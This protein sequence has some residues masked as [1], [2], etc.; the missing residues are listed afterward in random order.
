[1]DKGEFASMQFVIKAL[2]RVLPKP[3]KHLLWETA[4]GAQ[5]LSRATAE[6]IERFRIRRML[7][8]PAY[9][10]HVRR[11]Y[12]A[13]A[14]EVVFVSDV[15][16]GREAKF[17]H[18]LRGRG[19]TVTLL[20][21]TAPNY[22]VRRY[23]DRSIAYSDADALLGHASAMRPVAY[24][25][26]SLAGDTS[27]IRLINAKIGPTVFDT[28]DLLEASYLGNA[29]SLEKARHLIDMQAYALRYADGYC[30][31]DLQFRYARRLLGYKLG[32]RPIFFPEYCWGTAQLPLGNEV[33]DPTRTIRCVMAGN[34]G[35][36]KLGQGDWGYLEI[37]K[38]FSAAKIALDLY[39]NWIHYRSGEEEFTRIF[40]DYLDLARTSPH[41]K[42]HR[43]VRVDELEQR[44][45][46]YDFGVN[47]NWAEVSGGRST[48]FNAGFH[49]YCMSARVFDY[50]DAG[51]PVILSK[52]HRLVHAMLRRYR[53][54]IPADAEFMGA[55][56]Q[57]LRPFASVDARRRA[58]AA[59]RGLAIA[60]HI[61]R[62]EAFYTQ[63]AKEA[64]V[65]VTAR[66]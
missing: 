19:W 27:C 32:G 12:A 11:R 15:P 44:L 30:A 42:L 9:L 10:A 65:S 31:R 43:P 61:H 60:R 17:A 55:I 38:K 41:F 14:R 48:T 21:K 66:A 13:S 35:V 37:A 34:F 7:R 46:E 58:V 1:M 57:H 45:G 20:H 8:A 24:H 39:P 51:L 4:M 2:G 54:G 25:L 28:T 59:S 47:I 64:G 62:L 50:L 26:F 18:A 49:P 6:S 53:V 33:P 22:E 5:R 23:F 29:K 40:S 63:V 36:E 3:V 52:S 56:E 16:R